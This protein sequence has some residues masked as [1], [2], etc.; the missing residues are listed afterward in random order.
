MDIMYLRVEAG[1]SHDAQLLF[2]QHICHWPVEAF[3]QC[4]RIRSLVAGAFCAV[5]MLVAM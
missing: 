4:Q 5:L 3:T 1:Q 2:R